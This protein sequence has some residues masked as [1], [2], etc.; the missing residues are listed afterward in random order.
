M[1]WDVSKKWSI[2]LISND[3]GASLRSITLPF[4]V[5]SRRISFH[6][7]GK[8]ITQIFSNGEDLSLLLIPV[9]GGKTQ[10]IDGLGKGSSYRS[11]WSSD[12]KQFLYPLITETRDAVLLTDF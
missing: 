3:T 2:A 12:G 8:Y 5:Y 4:P 9:D 6:P 1:D 11:Q 7:S 10:I